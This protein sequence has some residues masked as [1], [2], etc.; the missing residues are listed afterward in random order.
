LKRP[1]EER[2]KRGGSPCSLCEKE[3]SYAKGSHP[4][5]GGK[6]KEIGSLEQLREKEWRRNTSD[7]A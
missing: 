4:S 5:L 1:A 7:P 6:K 2:G 3:R